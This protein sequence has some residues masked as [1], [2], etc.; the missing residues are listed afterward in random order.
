[1]ARQPRAVFAGLSHLVALRVQH[2][3][4]LA[5]DDEDRANAVR[6]LG[7]AMRGQGA[8]LHAYG[9]KQ[10]LVELVVTPPSA[11]ALSRAMQAFARRHTAAF[12]RRHGRHGG[13]W[14]GRFAAT[15]LESEPWL[16]RAMVRV[17][18]PTAESVRQW[19]S[20]AHHVGLR[21]DPLINEPTTYWS[22]GNTPF[23]R[24]ARYR[25]LLLEKAPVEWT[26][27]LDSAL[28]GG[29]PL[30]SEP[31]LAALGA[32]AQRSFTRPLRGRPPK[33]RSATQN[34]SPI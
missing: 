18:Q 17:E 2:Q 14:A 13:L 30:G 34:V 10:D 20:A 23:E 28:R 24:E 3:Q 33:S 1:M 8:S 16:L 22:L 31:F 19:S 15:A 6:L 27:A 4:S 9:L 12:N 25:L 29:R 7:E 32:T 5:V 11:D 21:S 26:Q